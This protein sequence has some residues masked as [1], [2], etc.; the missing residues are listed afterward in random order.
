MTKN[1]F[2][3]TIAV[4]LKREGFLKKGTYWYREKKDYL[5]CFWIQGSQWEKDDYYVEIGFADKLPNRR[6]P[7]Y[8]HWFA[9]HRCKRNN[10]EINLAL[11]DVL[12]ECSMFFK[13]FSTKTDVLRFV[14]TFSP[15]NIAGQYRF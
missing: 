11:H 3:S 13:N 7:S 12:S 4:E 2:T 8:L 6:Y 1:E 5:E 15:V 14:N 9:A 10:C